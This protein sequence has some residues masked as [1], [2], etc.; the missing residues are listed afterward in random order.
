MSGPILCQRV[1]LIEERLLLES[2]QSLTG[3][4]ETWISQNK[5]K[6]NRQVKPDTGQ[7][8]SR[9]ELGAQPIVCENI[10]RH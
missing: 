8:V 9:E 10:F 3:S 7:W 6:R 4:L 1:H 2:R 5:K